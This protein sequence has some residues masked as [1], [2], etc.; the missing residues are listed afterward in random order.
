MKE[1]RERKKEKERKK[2][3]ENKNIWKLL[4]DKSEY[5]KLNKKK[6]QTNKRQKGRKE[7]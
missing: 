6:E 3:K 2:N 7:I 1:N 5:I 4:A